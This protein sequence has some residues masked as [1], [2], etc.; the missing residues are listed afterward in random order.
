V[1]DGVHTPVASSH[2][3]VCPGGGWNRE[4]ATI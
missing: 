1:V 4:L 2:P 3:E